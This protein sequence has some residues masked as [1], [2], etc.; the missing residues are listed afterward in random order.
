MVILNNILYLMKETNCD[1]LKLASALGLNRQAVTDWKAG[2]NKSYM[3]YLYQIADFFGVT[4][5]ELRN[6]EGVSL[7]N[8]N[9]LQAVPKEE[10]VNPTS[11]G[12]SPEK[13]KLSS[14]LET[15]SPEQLRQVADYVDFILSKRK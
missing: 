13:D 1:N 12:E 6:E 11:V 10:G 5:E 8:R 9:F 2:R 3:K 14:L 7:K 15:L 4:V